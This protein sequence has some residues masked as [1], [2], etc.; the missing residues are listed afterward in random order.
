[1]ALCDDSAKDAV[2]RRLTVAIVTAVAGGLLMAL[3]FPPAGILR[4]FAVAGPLLLALSV[5]GL[6]ARTAYLVAFVFGMAFFVP[7]I[8]WAGEF[9]G[10][11]PWTALAVYQSVFVGILGPALVAI[12]RLRVWPAWAAC[13]WVAIE[14]LRSR[15]L[16][17]G[18][19]WGRLGFSQD[20]GPFT[21]WVAYGG[22]PLLSAVIALCGF[23]LADAWLRARTAAWARGGLSIRTAFTRPVLVVVGSALLLPAVGALGWLRITSGDDSDVPS[24]TIA[25]IQGNVPR[26][27]L[28]FNAQRRAVLDNH[29]RETLKLA[30]DVA[31]GRSPRPTVVLWP[32]NSSDIDPFTNADA[33]TQIQRAADAI[34]AP[35]LVGAV[36]NGP[37]DGVRN[38][39]IMWWPSGANNPGPGQNYV[40]R[41][42]VPFAEYV[43]YRDFFRK[44]TP[45]VDQVRADF[46]A[47][48]R[49]GTFEVSQDDAQPLVIGDVICFEVAHD[50]LVSDTIA[51]GAQ[52]LTI[53][54]N[55]AT[56]G[57]TREAD[58]QFAMS[59]IRAV[60]HNR[61]VLSA[62]TSGISGIIL[63]DGTV[64]AESGKFVPATYVQSVPLMDTT[65]IATRVGAWPEW[66]MRAAALVGVVLGFIRRPRTPRQRGSRH[67]RQRSY[68]TV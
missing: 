19:P 25:V 16:F 67:R 12:Y 39:A 56:F 30:D 13:A 46:V 40:K 59:R 63:P 14:V 42:P 18:F 15:Y 43:P 26:A 31:R 10:W 53:Q 24:A 52:I 64:V 61:T 66:I 68:A 38:M 9:L 48:K 58:Q 35:I 49:V 21:P 29:V 23:L 5:R 1:M 47:G 32:E 41:H 17:G 44:I 28:E 36:V 4:L 27:G 2:V 54:T 20:A 50:D 37:G 7:H 11:L 33:A 57:H 6:R 62:S 55:N 3:A 51:Q 22:V 65:T 8:A 34:D 45:M 60:E